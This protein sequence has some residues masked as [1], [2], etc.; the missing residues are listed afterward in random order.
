MLGVIE[1]TQNRI[2]AAVE[3]IERAL[4]LNPKAPAYYLN[5]GLCH[6]RRERFAEALAA[7]AQCLRHA[8]AMLDAHFNC[9]VVQTRIGDFVA[10]E[11]SYQRVLALKADHLGAL[12]N[13]GE[14][15]LRENLAHKALVPLRRAV[16]AKP[17]LPQ[18]RLN[19]ALALTKAS[20]YHEALPHFDAVMAMRPDWT[21]ARSQHAKALASLG[22]HADALATLELA[23]AAQPEIADYRNDKGVV[24]AEVGRDDEAAEAFKDALRIEPDHPRAL[25][26]LSTSNRPG[27]PAPLLARIEA[28]LAQSPPADDQRLHL[29]FA[30]AA[31]YE[32]QGEVERAFA[33][34]DQGNRLRR[35]NYS[36]KDTAMRFARL[37]QVFSKQFFAGRT[38]F[39]APSE[40][41]V[42]IL[43]MPRSGTSLV[44]QIIASHPLVHG[45]GEL[46]SFHLMAAGVRRHLRLVAPYPDCIAEVD[47]AGAAR[48]GEDYLAELRRLDADAIRVTD[49]MPGNFE[50]LGLIASLLPRARVI[51]C[52]RD[53]VETCFSCFTTNF[54][55]D[56]PFAWDLR[57]LGEYYN[58]YRRLMAHWRAVLP[59]PILDVSYET[60]VEQP[61]PT[62][63]ALIEFCGLEWD[64]RCLQPH[65]TQRAVRTASMAQVRRPIYTTSA[66]RAERFARFLAPLRQTLG[67]TGA[68]ID[69]TEK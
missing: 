5:L 54:S 51:H 14:L 50:N 44:E 11:K 56:Q 63:R 31:Y 34:Y 48:L 29:H 19:L 30:A 60:L 69:A 33:H 52:V 41:P 24:L 2:E 18:S 20:A 12:N 66:R 45:A 8:P 62:I 43:G 23:I 1:L 47:R 55:A 53:P 49:K 13:L 17:D 22:R 6:V 38:D 27:A 35:P 68:V 28:R 7:F 4:Q 37:R 59:L 36:P 39:G 32:K 21:Q 46:R 40:L 16:S 26:N 3:L 9:G 10:A 42:F 25:F 61:E 15:L 67:L 58:E 57:H 65:L 64:D